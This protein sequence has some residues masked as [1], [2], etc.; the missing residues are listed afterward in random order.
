M[1]SE[2]PGF[3]EGFTLHVEEAD[4][5]FVGFLR[6]TENFQGT[7]ILETRWLSGR[8]YMKMARCQRS[9]WAVVT[10]SQA[11]VVSQELEQL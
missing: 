3:I 4:L 5:Y 7:A 1:D 8:S 10:K 9:S 2:R 11:R 6:A